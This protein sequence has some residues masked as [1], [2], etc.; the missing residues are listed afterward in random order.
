MNILAALM[1][2]VGLHLTF[3]GEGQEDSQIGAANIIFGAMLFS[4]VED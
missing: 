3:S 2:V 1:I 4:M